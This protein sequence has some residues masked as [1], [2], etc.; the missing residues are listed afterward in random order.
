MATPF[1][2]KEA[3]VQFAHS[4]GRMKLGLHLPKQSYAL[5]SKCIFTN[6]ASLIKSLPTLPVKPNKGRTVF[7][8]EN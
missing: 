2:E 8:L 5:K 4:V 7:L 3:C 1:L 6:T